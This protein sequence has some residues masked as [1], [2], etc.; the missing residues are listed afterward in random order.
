MERVGS[1]DFWAEAS[2]GKRTDCNRV[3]DP[4][5]GSDRIFVQ[6]ERFVEDHGGR[7]G[8]TSVYGQRRTHLY[9]AMEFFEKYLSVASGPF[10]ATNSLIT[11]NTV[12]YGASRSLTGQLLP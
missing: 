7:I 1:A 3:F 4:C 10:P 9:A 5:Y 11:R 2:T 12:A 8:D 6:N